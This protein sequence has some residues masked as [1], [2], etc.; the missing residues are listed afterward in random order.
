MFWKQ[1]WLLYSELI[2]IMSFQI[3]EIWFYSQYAEGLVCKCND[4]IQHLYLQTVSSPAVK[5]QDSRGYGCSCH[6]LLK[7][8]KSIPEY[9]SLVFCLKSSLALIK[10][11]SWTLHMI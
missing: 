6:T 1:S 2:P 8:L 7:L 5:L 3:S 9:L 4:K 11:D 10:K